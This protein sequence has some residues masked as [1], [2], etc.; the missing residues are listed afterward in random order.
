MILTMFSPPHIFGDLGKPCSSHL[1]EMDH[2]FRSAFSVATL[3]EAKH[4]MHQS[5]PWKQSQT[6][7]FSSSSR[8]LLTNVYVLCFPSLFLHKFLVAQWIW[9]VT[10]NLVEWRKLFCSA[11]TS[12]SDRIAESQGSLAWR[13]QV[14]GGFCSRPFSGCYC[15]FG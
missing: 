8:D 12:W 15:R 7:E 5:W 4:P 1:K 9:S 13:S 14:T 2:H 10:A 11:K 6:M 3:T